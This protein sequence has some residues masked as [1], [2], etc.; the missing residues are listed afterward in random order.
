[1]CDVN[2]LVIGNLSVLQLFYT[3]TGR[4]YTYKSF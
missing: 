4:K 2:V 1:M 3:E